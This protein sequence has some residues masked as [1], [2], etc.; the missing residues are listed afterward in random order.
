MTLSAV[1]KVRGMSRRFVA[2]VF[3]FAVVSLF[4]ACNRVKYPE[5]F[6][7]IVP[8]TITVVDGGSP[9]EGVKATLD[10]ADSSMTKWGT[11][12]FSD[13]SGV[14]NFLTRGYEGAP[15]GG[16]TILL[17]KRD[18]P[19]SVGSDGMP[20][21]NSTENQLDDQFSDPDASPFKFEVSKKSKGAVVDL[22]AGTVTV[23]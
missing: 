23:N 16:C 10:Y 2:V 22:S 5:G 9:V 21:V 11:A 20:F 15:Q 19:I 13:A 12:G 7:K 14:V 8:C 6:P 4:S 17:E 3:F 18:P 1:R